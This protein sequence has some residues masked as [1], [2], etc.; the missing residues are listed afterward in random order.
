MTLSIVE[1]P[2][3]C[4]LLGKGSDWYVFQG[5]RMLDNGFH[6]EEDSQMM[7]NVARWERIRLSSCQ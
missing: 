6:P 4:T 3:E 2:A 5:G 7:L 1:H